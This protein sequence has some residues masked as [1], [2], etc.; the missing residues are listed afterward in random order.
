MRKMIDYLKKKGYSQA[1]LSVQKANY[2]IKLYKKVG[3]QIIRDENQEYV[4]CLQ[5]N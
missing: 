3:F 2:A 4:M 5:L 1:S